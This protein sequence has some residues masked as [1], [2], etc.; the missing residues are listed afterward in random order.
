MN[1]TAFDAQGEEQPVTVVANWRSYDDCFFAAW[2]AEMGGLW[3]Y[4]CV[5]GLPG[6]PQ[7]ERRCGQGAPIFGIKT[8]KKAKQTALADIQGWFESYYNSN[9]HKW[10]NAIDDALD[11][12]DYIAPLPIDGIDEDK[13]SVQETHEYRQLSLFDDL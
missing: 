4:G 6:T 7:M 10:D 3:W 2:I 11:A 9:G 8:A 13:E 5:A 1:A 12:I